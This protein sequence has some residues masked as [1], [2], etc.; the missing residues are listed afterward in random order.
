MDLDQLLADTAW[1]RTL[2]RSLVLD[3]HHADDIAQ[4]ALLVALESPPAE[5]HQLRA[6]LRAVS[7][8]LW[9]N[10]RRA[11]ARRAERERRVARSEAGPDVADTF[12][13]MELKRAVAAAVVALHVWKDRPALPLK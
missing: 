7:R 10:T 8:R 5:T 13:R 4:Q 11:E 3:E 12:E 6:W 9:F 1:I 2:S